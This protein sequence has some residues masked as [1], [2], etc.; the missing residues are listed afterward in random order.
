MI[1]VGD[2]EAIG[3]AFQ[4]GGNSVLT[5]PVARGEVGQIWKL[6]TSDGDGQ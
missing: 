1:T 5:G 3:S 2:A 6:T 4:L